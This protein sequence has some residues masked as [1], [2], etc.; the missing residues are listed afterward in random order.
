VVKYLKVDKKTKP[1]VFLP[2]GHP[3]QRMN[4]NQAA[5]NE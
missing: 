5:V 4:Y 3:V 2:E 1:P